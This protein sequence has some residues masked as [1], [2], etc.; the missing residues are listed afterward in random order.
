MLRRNTAASG[1]GCAKPEREGRTMRRMMLAVGVALLLGWTVPAWGNHS[2]STGINCPNFAFQEDAQ[3]YFEQH[4]GDPEGLDGPPGPTSTGVPGLACEDLPRRGSTTTVATIPATTT[5]APAVAGR[6]S[7]GNSGAAS[8]A[9]AEPNTSSQLL[10]GASQTTTTVTTLVTV[11]TTVPATVP[12]TST[13]APATAT[14]GRT[15]A[16]TG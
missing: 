8:N 11:A 7:A 2:V 16:L 4:P 14:A 5:T 10:A 12:A 6:P 13:A 9:T 15:L 1:L 3:A